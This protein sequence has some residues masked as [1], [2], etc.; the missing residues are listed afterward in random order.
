MNYTVYIIITLLIHYLHRH[1]H[2]HRHRHTHT[3]THSHKNIYMF[4][5]KNIGCQKSNLIIRIGYI[6]TSIVSCTYI[7]NLHGK[8]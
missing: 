5:T 3:H 2:R 8:L 7:Y 1:R 4:Y 6:V